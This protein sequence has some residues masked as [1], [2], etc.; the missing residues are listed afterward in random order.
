MYHR[1]QCFDRD[2]SLEFEPVESLNVL[3]IH[4]QMQL[5]VTQT[6][7]WNKKMHLELFKHFLYASVYNNNRHVAKNI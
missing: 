1:Q 3:G 2:V 6:V 4:I 5:P 7:L